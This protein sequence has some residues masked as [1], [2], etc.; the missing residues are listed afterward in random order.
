MLPAVFR[1]YSCR[2]SDTQLGNWT[3]KHSVDSCL[4]LP[5]VMQKRRQ[6]LWNEAVETFLRERYGF[7]CP[8]KMVSMGI[9]G[10]VGVSVPG[11]WNS[12]K[13]DYRRGQM[14]IEPR[15]HPGEQVNTAEAHWDHISEGFEQSPSPVW[16][17]SETAWSWRIT[18]KE[19]QKSLFTYFH[20]M[21]LY[22]NGT[23]LPK[24]IYLPSFP[25][26]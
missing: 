3:A 23:H 20:Q 6:V 12:I 24:S 9:D 26:Q 5:K 4:S 8:Q 25:S 19:N 1:T 13:R 11:W 16:G 18:S 22:I 7:C 21:P 2:E 17:V 10:G 14:V 15:D